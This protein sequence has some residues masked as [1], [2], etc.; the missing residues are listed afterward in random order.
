MEWEEHKLVVRTLS[1]TVLSFLSL[2]FNNPPIKN[3]LFLFLCTSVFV[4][5]TYVRCRDTTRAIRS[6]ET[7]LTGGC[8]LPGIQIQVLQKR[9]KC[10]QQLCISAA[11]YSV[12]S[13]VSFKTP[14]FALP[15]NLHSY[16]L[17]CVFK[18]LY[19]KSKGK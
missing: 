19:P 9:S 12:S 16:N 10:S 17:N 5:H 11:L 1:P 8:D 13:T 15:I 7:I 14:V 3:D 18:P 6:L 2:S 4:C